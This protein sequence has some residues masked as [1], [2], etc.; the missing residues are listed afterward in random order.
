MLTDFPEF[1]NLT[2]C[3][4]IWTGY[5][6]YRDSVAESVDLPL[7]LRD[8]DRYL[9]GESAAVQLKDDILRC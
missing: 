5:E 1:N 2:D 9:W 4:K 6:K 7:N 3:E 8:K